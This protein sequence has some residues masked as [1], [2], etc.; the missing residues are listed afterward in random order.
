[1]NKI[2]RKDELWA[3]FQQ[4]PAQNTAQLRSAFDAVISCYE[5]PHR[6]YHNVNHLHD[7]SVEFNKHADKFGA[8]KAA[9]IAALFYHDI[10]YECVPKQDEQ[11]SAAQAK[12][13]LTQ[14]GIDRAIINDACQ[15]ISDTADH[16]STASYAAKLFLDMDMSILAAAPNIYKAYATGVRDEFCTKQNLTHD[17]FKAA[18]TQMFLTP[19]LNGKVIFKTAE[20]KK[21]ESIARQNIAWEL[22]NFK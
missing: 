13:A 18:R 4:L 20:Y 22:N 7:L 21:Y 15:I 16:S 6:A 3:L 9:V 19:V 17:A 2:G 10:V 11:Q 14:L 1:M 5:Q 12:I 8:D